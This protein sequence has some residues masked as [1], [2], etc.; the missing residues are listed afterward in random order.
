MVDFIKRD[1][2]DIFKYKILSFLFKNPK[3][4][5]VLR[6]FTS[7]LF[8][9]AIYF[10][11]INQDK[12][13]IFT[14]AIFWSLFWSFF[15][16][17]TLPTLGRVFCSICPHGFIGK[18]ITRFGLKKKMPK[19]LENRFIG[20]FILVVLWWGTYYTFPGLLKTPIGTSIMF[21]VLS[22]LAFIMY[23][24]YKDMSYCKS[25][26]PIGTLT[27]V[28]DKLA[29][30]KLQTYK[31]ACKD[32]KTF[33]CASACSYGLKP[34]TFEKKNNTEDC[35]LCMDCAQ[36][37]ESVA[38][39]I[40]PP[41]KKL[42]GKFKTYTVEVWA[43]ILILAAIPISM[44]FAHALQRSNIAEQMIW[45]TTAEFL[46]LSS[47]NGMFA[48]SYAI[49]FTS[50]AT[51]FGL[52]LAS[53]VLKKDFTYTLKTTGYAYAPLFIYGSFVH[54]LEK[55]FTKGYEKIVK[56]FSQGFN[57]NTEV[58]SLAQRGDEFLHYFS[59]LREFAIIFTL[60][61]IYIRLKQFDASKIRK[62]IAYFF[63]S[64][65]VIFFISVNM[66]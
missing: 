17:I 40:I 60:Y 35:T 13:N 25:I 57:L 65:I 36:V 50:F 48:I 54:T 9:Y 19:F 2:K 64:F 45:N 39:N 24:I 34:F 44:T 12:S 41:G 30:T 10:G 28:Y 4:L 26:C 3:F 5:L 1:K 37:C 66:Y 14:P 33:E 62:I 42:E 20:I 32:C 11:Y 58:T 22:F 47:L 38:F 29:M 31:S 56:G 63:L 46:N 49:L 52:Y 23:F 7:F 51:V 55:F 43:Y 53:K 18:Y 8:F 6:L 16:I 15:M 27:K 59:Y 61:L 21:T